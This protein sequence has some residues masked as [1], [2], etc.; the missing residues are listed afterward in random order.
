MRI[1]RVFPR[2]TTATPIADEYVFIGHPPLWWPDDAQ[3]VHVSVTFT[4]DLDA[5]YDL[6]DEWAMAT[7]L[8]VSIGG[9]AT[10]TP[11]DEFVPGRYLKHGYTITSRGCPNRC[12]FCSV[13]KRENGL[14][15][16]PI[17]DGWIVQDDNLL[18]CS[19][20]HIREV[21]SMLKR[22]SH[23][24]DLR[25]LEAKALKDWHID[26]LS[27]LRP[28]AAW[29]A[30]DTPDD[31]E[32]LWDAGQRLQAAGMS[33][34]KPLRAYV[35]IGQPGDTISK[36]RDRLLETYRAGF[37]PFAMLWSDETGSYDYQWRG[38]QRQWARPAITRSVIAG[39]TPG[40]SQAESLL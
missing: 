18:A 21:F 8:P 31:W 24:A 36:A 40:R 25:G 35:L 15:E 27:D 22:Q 30:Y 3:E 37:W 28:A 26:L 34:E 5:A 20:A 2:Q 1:I 29:F 7:H 14:R 16:L 23:P 10:G 12:W 4:W 13:W 6:G 39:K 32:P 9:P 33:P 11:G 38:F 19:E 17:R